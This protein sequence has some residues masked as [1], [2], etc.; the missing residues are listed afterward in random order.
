MNSKPTKILLI[1]DSMEDAIIIR[2]MLKETSN[3]F[4]MEHVD[5]LKT[6][7]ETLFKDS[8]DLILLDLNLPKKDGRE[9]LEEIKN[10]GVLK[11]IPVIILST[12]KNET[13]IHRTYELKANCYISKPVELDHFF[14]IILELERF[15]LNT[16][17]LPQN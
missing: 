10:D 6:G 7:F 12:S 13:D 8:F 9:V 11:S 17:K 5:R 14:D 4:K 3:T 1:E 15:W 16:V 2:E